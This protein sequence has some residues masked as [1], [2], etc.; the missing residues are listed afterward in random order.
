MHD[1]RRIR[2][3][4]CPFDAITQGQA[5]EKCFRWR[6]QPRTS[7][8][9]ITVNVGI[10]MMMRKDPQLK[11]ACLGA[12][13]VVADGLPVVWA[14]RLLGVPLPG[15]VSG[16]DLMQRLLVDGG[17]RHLRVYLLGATEEVVTTL[18]RDIEQ[19][20]AGVRVVGY[21]NG[22]FS[23][24][25]YPDV[26][27]DIRQNRADVLFVG[28][29]TPFKEVWCHRYRE[30]LG[31]PA[32]IGVGGSFDVL[33][34]FVRRAPRWMQNCGMEWF[35]R[36]LMEPRRMWKRYLTT[37]SLFLLLLGRMLLDRWLA[38]PIPAGRQVEPYR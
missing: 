27:Q 20:Y 10:L 3:M 9:L 15:R 34:G 22:F 24:D 36:V 23:P 21:R 16:V 13:L 33:A 28:M 26:V 25:D 2:L 5:L 4:G 35:W 11:E 37:N 19:N 32:I 6:E 29:P 12:E 14:S 30:E 38:D 18:V 7:R 1:N 31:T 8:L 17:A